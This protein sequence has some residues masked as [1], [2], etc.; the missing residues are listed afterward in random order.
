MKQKMKPIKIAHHTLG[1]GYS[2]FVIAEM[3]ANH[4]KNIMVPKNEL[5][6]K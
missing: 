5:K 2:C 1:E 6:G 3:S 4:N